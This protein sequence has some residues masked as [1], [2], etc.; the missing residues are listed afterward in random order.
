MT[1]LIRALSLISILVGLYAIGHFGV[2]S[3]EAEYPDGLPILR[4]RTVTQ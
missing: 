2:E 1:R 3:L 4:I